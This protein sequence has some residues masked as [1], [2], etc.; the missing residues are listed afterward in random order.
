M[1]QGNVLTITWDKTLLC[2]RPDIM[3]KGIGGVKVDSW[4]SRL[5]ELKTLSQQ[6][7]ESEQKAGTPSELQV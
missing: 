5:G 2:W 1:E 7:H 6:Q 3:P 4:V